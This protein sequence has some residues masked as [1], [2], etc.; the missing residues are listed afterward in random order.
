MLSVVCDANNEV[1]VYSETHLQTQIVKFLR[2]YEDM[3]IV[4]SSFGN[5]N[6]LDTDE[7]RINM[8]KQGYVNGTPDLLIFNRNKKYTM[9]CIEFKNP[10]F[11][12]GL[13][14]E[15]TKYLHKLLEVN[16]PYILVSNNYTHII[17]TIVKYI[18]NCL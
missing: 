7:K 14:D 8:Y 12:T 11:G 1:N 5:E 16:N 9:L 18:H 17:S 3:D 4:Y 2:E 13:S 10:K 6:Q 15:Q